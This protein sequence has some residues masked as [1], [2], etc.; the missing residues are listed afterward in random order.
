MTSCIATRL[1]S[2]LLKRRPSELGEAAPFSLSSADELTLDEK[3]Q[4][5]TES[6]IEITDI[7]IDL[8]E[9]GTNDI[10]SSDEL[11]EIDMDI[12]E[13]GTIDI[14]FTDDLTD[15]FP[16]MTLSDEVSLPT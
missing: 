3:F 1:D 16:C 5:D 4:S 11:T 10:D 12:D 8:D 13:A 7:D 9:A 2:S 6:A 15:S 14:D